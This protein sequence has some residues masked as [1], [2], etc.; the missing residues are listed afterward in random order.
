MNLSTSKEHGI[1]MTSSE[2][3]LRIFFTLGLSIFAGIAF[4]SVQAANP[5]QDKG[6]DKPVIQSVDRAWDVTWSRF[7]RNDTHLFYDYLSS[8]EEGKE[9]SH[10]PT[11]AEIE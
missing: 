1:L 11:V 5:N 2:K 3:N 9:L 8:Y 6:T 4:N 7:Y 10:L